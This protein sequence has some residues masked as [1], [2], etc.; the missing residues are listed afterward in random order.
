MNIIKSI[1]CSLL[2]IILL[3]SIIFKEES[4]DKSNLP[5]LKY[6]VTLKEAYKKISEKLDTNWKL[7]SISNLGVN[8][9]DFIQQYN[10]S[11]LDI[12]LNGINKNGSARTFIFEFISP[13]DTVKDNE[14]NRMVMFKAV[15]FSSDRETMIM[16][17][18]YDNDMKIISDTCINSFDR[19]C[20]ELFK[21]Y[22]C[23]L[24]TF[25]TNIDETGFHWEFTLYDLKKGEV[26]LIRT[27][28][29][30]VIDTTKKKPRKEKEVVA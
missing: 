17:N 26:R 19:A 22:T 11:A 12:Q 30:G 2:T 23:D 4:S 24:V 14:G 25:N 3:L 8:S 9:Q 7:T 28:E 1:G 5:I 15:I 29:N 16:Y 13:N 18:T 27:N 21:N 6:T 10:D 20:S